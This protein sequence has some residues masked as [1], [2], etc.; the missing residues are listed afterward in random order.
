MVG[1]NTYQRTPLQWALRRKKQAQTSIEVHRRGIANLEARIAELDAAIAE[2][3]GPPKPKKI[4]IDLRA[5]GEQ[6]RTMFDLM[7]E[8]GSITADDLARA[9][10]KAYGLD[11][12]DKAVMHTLRQ[13]AIQCLKRNERAGRVKHVSGVGKG[14]K[15]KRFALTFQ[16]PGI[17][18]PA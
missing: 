8:H 5:K 15:F 17:Q 6:Q 9:M 4:V 14:G 12:A 13:R 18:L 3:G 10:V 11:A 2:M 1:P 7:R 16:T